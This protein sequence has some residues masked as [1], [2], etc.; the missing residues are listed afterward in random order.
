MLKKLTAIVLTILLMASLCI[1]A[2][3]A[4]LSIESDT[5]TASKGDYVTMTVSLSGCANANTL[6][7]SISFN[8]NQLSLESGK[9]LVKGLLSDFD[10]AT[11]KGVLAVDDDNF[12]F[13]GDVFL[14]EFK[15]KDDSFDISS[16]SA[17][18]IVRND[19]ETVATVSASASVSGKGTHTHKYDQEV[20]S[21]EYLKSEPSC[22]E[23]AVYYYS[24]TCGEKGSATFTTDSADHV[25]KYV[26]DVLADCLNDGML[27]YYYCAVCQKAFYDSLGKTEIPDLAALIVK[28]TGIHTFSNGVCVVCGAIEEADVPAIDDDDNVPAI[29]DDD[30]VPAVDDEDDVIE[31]VCDHDFND[32]LWNDTY[33][34]RECTECKEIIEMSRHIASSSGSN[35]EEVICTVCGYLI[36]AAQ[37][38][39]TESE[40]T[41]PQITTTT[42]SDEPAIITTTEPAESAITTTTE[43][44]EEK[45]TATTTT[46]AET[47]PEVTTTQP[48]T[49]E[50]V[51]ISETG[52]DPMPE[53]EQSSN[54]EENLPA[55]SEVPKSNNTIVI[56]I[57]AVLAVI[58]VVGG[59]IGF[60]FY[61]K[62]IGQRS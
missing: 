35:G 20:E 33:H 34:W 55:D 17:Q 60:I 3:A 52:D 50:E 5:K 62:K 24:C 18:L 38:A 13:N 49:S 7:I 29:D 42:E 44:T 47:E 9:W 36:K 51:T 30:N 2:Y 16:V 25:M 31:S 8:T 39:Q 48:T 41:E 19:S 11:N 4:E 15:V 27:D 40:V 26:S 21:S 12:S 56:L 61:K 10:E 46:S 32:L 45:T 54:E 59:V 1:T 58:F 22:T 6:G 57:I 28:S 43:P 37:P 23:K 53:S 14:L